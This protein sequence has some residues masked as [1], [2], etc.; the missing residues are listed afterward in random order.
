MSSKFG[1]LKI[2]AAAIA[3]AATLPVAS[4]PA[5]ADA[6]S[7]SNEAYVKG[8]QFFQAGDYRSAR[9]LL[10]K[11]LKSNPNNGLARLM[12]AR[13]AIE[14]GG[15]VQAQTELERAVQ[16]GIPAEKV[17][18]LR[19][20]ALILQRKLAQA[21]DLLDPRTIPPQFSAYA[22]RLRGQILAQQSKQPEAFAEFETALRLA[23]NDADTKLDAARFYAATGNGT[24]SAELVDQVL[25]AK[26]TSAKGLLLKGDLVRRTQ[27]LEPSLTYFNRAIEVDPNNIEALLERA[28]TLGDM[29][30]DDQARADLKRINGLIPDHPLALY[31]EAVIETRAGSYEKA[32]ALMTRTKGTLSNYTPA[33][34]LQGMLAYQANDTAQA[35]DYFGKVVGASPQSALARK[36]YAAAQLRG[37]DVRGAIATLK[38]IIDAG[39]ADGRVYALYG[40]AFARQ[41]DMEQA[42]KYLQQAVEV[43]PQAGELKTQ[44]AMTQL[45]QGNADAAEDEL[46]DV[47]K[48]DNKSLQALMVLSLVQLRDKQFDKAI[49]T[50]NRIIAIYPDIPVGYNI[51]GGAL[52]GLADTKKAEASFRMALQKKPDYIEARRNLAQVLIAN[53]RLAEAERELKTILETNKRDS[54]ALVLLAS[55]AERRGDSSAQIEWLRQATSADTSK[56]GPR[57]QLASA[58]LSSRQEKKSLDETASL[59]RDFPEEP[60]ALITASRIYEATN[61]RDRMESVLNRLVT[62]QPEATSARI[63]LAR[64]LEQNK[65]IPAARSTYERALTMTDVDTAPIAV[66]MIFFEARQ[67][68]V[69]AAKAVA[70]RLR[71]QQPKSINADL[72]MGRVMLGQRK[73]VEA[74][75]YLAAAKR[76]AFTSPVARATSEAYV[77]SGKPAEAITVLREYQKANPRDASALTAIAELQLNQ[78]QYKAAAANYEALR[79]LP[80]GQASPLVLNNLAWAYSQLGD[81]RALATAKAAYTAAPKLPAIQDT[82][83]WVMLRS[84]TNPKEAL[85]LL[86]SAAASAP[87]DP[88][89]RFHLGVAYQ[90]N[91]QRAKAVGALQ[92]ALKTPKFENRAAAQTLLGKLQGG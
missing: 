47:L 42:Q 70:D 12:Q 36:L 72:A 37:N 66:E 17:R 85:S 54:R 65:K 80:G 88:N 6:R 23:P 84:K 77:Q 7:E 64:A 30:R 79:K 26:P 89:I 1:T 4:S 38:P 40:A 21:Y 78:K 52:L 73:P 90:V 22:A 27:G 82:Y 25:A 71:R 56:F 53:K 45:L 49:A 76:I 48:T 29:K 51:R 61:Q 60:L 81:K 87:S 50:S 2:A 11:A 67:G 69:A 35:A 58:Y 24:K 91:G 59:L 55:L 28:A 16:A 14:L 3:I 34:M 46:M 15:G 74:L 8:F 63:M 92:A 20:H 57:A 13:V 5:A 18:H 32:R 44:L 19:A 31:L 41:G 86:Q 10:L 9:I 83:G 68:N 75:Q 33:L 62:L 43:A 39:A